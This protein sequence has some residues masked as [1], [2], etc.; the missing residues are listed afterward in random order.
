M[1]S[2][3]GQQ[4]EAPQAAKKHVGTLENLQYSKK[5]VFLKKPVYS[6]ITSEKQVIEFQPEKKWVVGSVGIHIYIYKYRCVI[7]VL[8]ALY[9]TSAVTRK[10]VNGWLC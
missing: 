3:Y 4:V 7:F 9:F 1:K 8:R 10:L 2:V 5:Q 6:R